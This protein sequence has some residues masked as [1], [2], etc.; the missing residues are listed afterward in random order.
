MSE[1]WSVI[2]QNLAPLLM[3]RLYAK[4]FFELWNPLVDSLPRG[5]EWSTRGYLRRYLHRLEGG[6]DTS[7]IDGWFDRTSSY[8]E[9]YWGHAI[10]DPHFYNRL[11]TAGGQW[12]HRSVIGAAAD[13]GITNLFQGANSIAESGQVPGTLNRFLRDPKVDLAYQ[14]I[15]DLKIGI[16]EEMQHYMF[17]HTGEGEKYNPM[18]IQGIGPQRLR[19]FDQFI[20]RWTMKP[21]QWT[22]SWNRGNAMLQAL[23]AA[24]KQG[25]DFNNALLLG[26][27][28]QSSVF[29]PVR[30]SDAVRQSLEAVQRTQFGY[31][32]ASQTPYMQTPGMKL[33]TIFH[34]YPTKQA[35]L[36]SNTL[37]E[38]F[39]GF[40]KSHPDASTAR[41][42]RYTILAGGMMALVQGTLEYAGIDAGSLTSFLPQLIGITMQPMLLAFNYV[43][44]KEPVTIKDMTDAGRNIIYHF[45]IPGYRYWWEKVG[46]HPVIS[47]LNKAFGSGDWTN[48]KGIIASDQRGWTLNERNQ[49]MYDTDWSEWSRLTGITV[50]QAAEQRIYNRAVHKFKT[51]YDQDREWTIRK[52]LQDQDGDRIA[53]FNEK[54]APHHP[55]LAISGKDISEAMQSGSVPYHVRI[56]EAIKRGTQNKTGFMP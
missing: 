17:R 54:W 9:N 46:A 30:V 36:L 18:K 19:E 32:V 13:T 52:F 51:E 3:D 28:R 15:R 56:P 24:R 26:Y 44:G 41:L 1:N 38:E 33:M 20:T 42:I 25:L 34:S 39:V 50:G 6:R 53:K 35:Q 27:A 10:T 48:P 12:V 14:Q 21:M 23:E 37:A 11:M 8:V 29:Q 16:I 49:R 7:A 45:G 2:F 5:K 40:L 43:S 55:D 22:E 47:P 4:P 31:G